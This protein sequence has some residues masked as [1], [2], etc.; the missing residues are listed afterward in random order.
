MKKV[1][2]VFGLLL[3]VAVIAFYT[4]QSSRDPAQAAGG[5]AGAAG[6]RGGAP[7]AVAAA[8]SVGA[9]EGRPAP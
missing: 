8:D 5:G 7:A 6:G 4:G 1:A 9:V 3:A 2:L